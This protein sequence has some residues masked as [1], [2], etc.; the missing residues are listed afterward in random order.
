M[1]TKNR[2]FK[3]RLRGLSPLLKRQSLQINPL[4]ETGLI[5]IILSVS[6]LKSGLIGKKY[7]FFD[8]FSKKMG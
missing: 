7:E 3:K 4:R 2:S 1:E 5:W 6:R 8:F